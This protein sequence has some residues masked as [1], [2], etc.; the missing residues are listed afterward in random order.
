M[1]FH[2]IIGTPNRL[3]ETK[4]QIKCFPTTQPV[5]CDSLSV[6]FGCHSA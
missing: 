6:E 1:K 2:M 5:V 3:C 4:L